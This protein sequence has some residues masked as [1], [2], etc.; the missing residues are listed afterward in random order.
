MTPGIPY[1]SLDEHIAAER[2]ARSRLAEH[3]YSLERAGRGYTATIGGFSFH[4]NSARE[5][6]ADVE[7][8]RR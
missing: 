4:T 7:G 3:G 6:L 5:L 8:R 2:E 1:L